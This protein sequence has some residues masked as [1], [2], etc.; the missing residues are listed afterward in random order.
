MPEKID[1]LRYTETT[2]QDC[3]GGYK[4]SRCDSIAKEGNKSVDKFNKVIYDV[5]EVCSKQK[6][7]TSCRSTIESLK[8][9]VSL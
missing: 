3:V 7:Y 8:Y 6:K 4:N 1:E 2:W 9:G 5:D